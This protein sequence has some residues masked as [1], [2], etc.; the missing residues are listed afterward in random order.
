M[1][2]ED[3]AFSSQVMAGLKRLTKSKFW[4]WGIIMPSS[5][6]EKLYV[7][8]TADLYLVFVFG[9]FLII[10]SVKHSLTMFLIEQA[11]QIQVLLARTAQKFLPKHMFS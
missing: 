4:K 9:F 3:S 2:E 8:I 7:E 6:S 1:A 5:S 11:M 10:I